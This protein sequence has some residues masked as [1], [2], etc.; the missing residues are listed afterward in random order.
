MVNSTAEIK[1]LLDKAPSVAQ[2]WKNNRDPIE[3]IV[4]KKANSKDFYQCTSA[5]LALTALMSMPF[6]P[7]SWVALGVML[8]A[9]FGAYLSS[10]HAHKPI[11]LNSCDF[12]PQ[13]D[14]GLDVYLFEK[15]VPLEKRKE[16]LQIIVNHPDQRIRELVP[17]LKPL[18]NLDLP[19][20]WW[21]KL[22]N[23]VLPLCPIAPNVEQ[24]LQTVFVEIDQQCYTQEQPKTL[25]L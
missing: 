8:S 9:G 21:E 25:R 18:Q 4:K 7:I 5:L 12:N 23:L 14:V 11:A 24:Q 3:K 1:H 16:V 15:K 17:N 13:K 19:D 6:I 10:S 22:H 2:W 20:A